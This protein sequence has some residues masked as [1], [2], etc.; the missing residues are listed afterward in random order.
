MSDSSVRVQKEGRGVRRLLS[1]LVEWSGIFEEF[2]DGWWE[3]WRG[4]GRCRRRVRFPGLWGKKREQGWARAVYLHWGPH[5]K[6][7]SWLHGAVCA[8]YAFPHA[9]HGGDGGGREEVGRTK[10]WGDGIFRTTG[11]SGVRKGRRGKGRGEVLRGEG[12]FMSK[13]AMGIVGPVTTL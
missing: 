2:C 13:F 3:S 1:T 4:S 10:D 11:G 8:E 7:V 6:A 9:N 5:L 12:S